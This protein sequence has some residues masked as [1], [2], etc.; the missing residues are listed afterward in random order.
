[1]RLYGLSVEWHFWCFCYGYNAYFI[2]IKWTKKG[3]KCYRGKTNAERIIFNQRNTY[4]KWWF[5]GFC[6][7][8]SSKG[9]LDYDKY[10]DDIEKL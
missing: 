3:L 9:F 2:L 1:M 4:P 10:L 6:I 7:V 5:L 8:D